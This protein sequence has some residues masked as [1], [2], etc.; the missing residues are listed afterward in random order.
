[1]FSEL[2][3]H[4]R[5]LV[6]SVLFHVAI[7]VMVF[8]DF[9]FR[10]KAI[11]VKQADLSK[12]VKAQII[13]RQQLEQQKNKKKAKE[14]KRK[15]DLAKQKRDKEA[16]KRKQAEAKKRKAEADKKK[17]AEAK[18]V[19][20][21]KQKAELAKKKEADKKHKLAEEKKRKELEK[22]KK[23][24]AEKQKKLAEEKR[25]QE[26]QLA[27]ELEQKRLL[28]EKKKQEAERRRL[29]EE[30]QKRRQQELNEILK[31]EETQ[32]RLNSL[33]EA[34]ILAIIQKIERNWRQPLE[35]GNMPDCRLKVLQGPGGIILDVSFG[36]CTGGSPTYR[37]SIEKAVYKAEPLPKPGDPSLFERELD[38]LFKPGN[39]Q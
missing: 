25:K 37:D 39:K 26:E 14:E 30:E 7:I 1:V 5:A 9:D 32:R 27:R 24:E 3:Q 34:Y 23:L 13:D 38:I 28:E 35:S 31:A 6:L 36:T 2:L 21:A 33:R 17:K 18:R 20:A 12:T 22:Q 19:E 29:A 11:L 15:K 4:P 8:I 16:K 10:D